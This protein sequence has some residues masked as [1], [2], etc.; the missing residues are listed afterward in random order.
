MRGCQDLGRCQELFNYLIIYLFYGAFSLIYFNLH[1]I[2]RFK[3]FLLHSLQ[4]KPSSKPSQKSSQKPSSKLPR[5]N[6][7]DQQLAREGL[8]K[9][10]TCSTQ[11]WNPAE[12][13]SALTLDKALEGPPLQVMA[14]NRPDPC[15]PIL[16]AYFQNVVNHEATDSAS[17]GEVLKIAFW[18]TVILCADPMQPFNALVYLSNSAVYIC[19]VLRD[20]CS[21]TWSGVDELPLK[22]VISCQLGKLQ[23]C[24]FGM[25]ALC[26]VGSN[27][28]CTFTLLTFSP[29][30]TEEIITVLQS[31][32]S[33]EGVPR[34][35]VTDTTRE[36]VATL[37]RELHQGSDLT[38]SY[39]INGDSNE[40]VDFVIYT[41]LI[42][43][44][45]SEA[46]NIA[47]GSLLP[48]VQLITLVNKGGMLYICQVN[49]LLGP[50]G[51]LGNMK[52]ATRK[53]MLQTF[54]PLS[55]LQAITMVDAQFVYMGSVFPLYALVLAFSNGAHWELLCCSHTEGEQLVLQLQESSGKDV[56]ISYCSDTSVVSANVVHLQSNGAHDVTQHVSFTDLKALYSC[57]SRRSKF[58]MSTSLHMV[59]AD[60][61]AAPEKLCQLCYAH[62]LPYSCKDDMFEVIVVLTN[63]HIHLVSSEAIAQRWNMSVS[64][65][66]I[67][68]AKNCYHDLV[69][70]MSVPIRNITEV[71]IG[72][73]DQSLRITSVDAAAV[74]SL[75]TGEE[76]V[77]E[78][79]LDHLKKHISHH[80]VHMQPSV[81][82]YSET[83]EF[84]KLKSCLESKGPMPC[85]P[86][87]IFGYLVVQE[88]HPNTGAS[89]GCVR[90]L[91][92]TSVGLHVVKED[93]VRWPLLPS[94]AVLPSWDRYEVERTCC[95]THVQGIEVSSPASNTFCVVMH[96]HRDALADEQLTINTP[97][98]CNSEQTSSVQWQ[99]IASSYI[100]REKF[101]SRLKEAWES[102]QQKA[103]PLPIILC[104]QDSVP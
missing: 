14:H 69:T 1:C 48:S 98:P 72:L 52:V 36:D 51:N 17:A 104:N 20:A 47:L 95:L 6:V 53:Y 2:Y 77:T 32:A 28:A 44:P 27:P 56:K 100:Q 91:V 90:T 30:V 25:D 59:G 92:V 82:R 37:C 41:S 76:L 101:L 8:S 26:F 49:H 46:A 97:I 88:H 86:T 64:A 79:I 7:A 103:L 22:P 96:T 9:S 67:P 34:V 29:K 21:R 57:L 65:V 12:A 4:L 24:T 11:V 58:H 81:F 66:S 23:K 55:H 68:V 71:A 63:Q 80:Q 89:A 19:E 31:R 38:L 5:R 85:E 35:A 43:I 84:D 15:N 73:F 83:L 42:Q 61:K 99:F 74:F 18:A 3:L 39:D 40:D 60:A 78:S 45:L 93:Y 13:L 75:I 87:H 94:M 102:V 62:C 70:L 16:Q 33:D 50:C 10:R 54:L